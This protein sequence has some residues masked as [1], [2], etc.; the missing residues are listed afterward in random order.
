MT[1]E[2]RA[3]QAKNMITKQ[4]Q[5]LEKSFR[6]FKSD[7]DI[8]AALERLIRWEKRTTDLIR[9]QVHPT[10]ATKFSNKRMMIPVA[11]DPAHR[12]AE[13][14]G[15]YDSF[16]LTLAEEIDEHPEGILSPAV[17]VETPGQQIGHNSEPSSD[18]FIIHGHDEEN[19]SR[20]KD[21]LHDE[22]DLPSIILAKKPG[23]G[24][25]LIEKF[26]QEAQSAI[27]AFAILTPDDVVSSKDKKYPQPRPNVIFELGWF[28]GRLHR[29]KVCILLRK[30][31]KIHSD[32][33]GISYIEFVES[34]LEKEGEIKKELL[35]ANILTK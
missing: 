25:T 6:R 18:I 14:C 10:E 12:F 28:C 33:A 2:E 32:L 7:H 3:E 11:G 19:R 30:G 13:D 20:L 27:Y 21:L 29:G 1:L 31:T 34:I 9:E 22:W 16:L 35:A 15:I 5:D 23:K 17:P 24:R 26:E 8:N 4:R